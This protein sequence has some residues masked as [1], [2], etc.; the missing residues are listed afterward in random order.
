MMNLSRITLRDCLKSQV[1]ARRRTMT[2]VIAI[3][4]I[5]SRMMSGLHSPCSSDDDGSARQRFV[6]RPSDGGHIRGGDGGR[7]VLLELRVALGEHLSRA[8]VVAG[9]MKEAQVRTCTHRMQA[10]VMYPSYVRKSSPA[11]RISGSGCWTA[12]SASLCVSAG[13]SST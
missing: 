4:I 3:R 12:L 10:E 1:R 11:S 8:G 5:A 7:A 13:S 2:R 9:V 6:Q